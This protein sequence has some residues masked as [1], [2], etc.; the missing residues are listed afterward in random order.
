LKRLLLCAIICI[1]A[2][3]FIWAQE[4]A[5]ADIS[6]GDEVQEKYQKNAWT[7]FWHGF[8][9]TLLTPQVHKPFSVFGG[10]EISQND[11]VHYLP[12]IFVAS[13]YELS[14]NFGIGVRGGMTFGSKEP[15]DSIVSVMEGVIY[16]R[17]Y[18]YDFGWIKPY[19]QAGLGISVDRELGYEYND[20]LGEFA[21]GVRAHYTG[22]FLDAS[23][24]YGY[25]FRMGG[26]IS[27]GHSFL[28]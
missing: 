4:E 6:I 11:R 16:G 25:P 10:I 18:V 13:D 20:F 24:R 19:T 15:A 26:G 12:E 27:I 22:W 1:L 28:P 14:P 5:E 3:S 23:F 21:V 9:V 8:G 7:R 2:G 17:F